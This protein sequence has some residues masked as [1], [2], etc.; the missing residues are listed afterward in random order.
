V[1]EEPFSIETMAVRATF[2]RAATTG[3]TLAAVAAA[4]AGAL[5]LT[6]GTAS[7]QSAELPETL[8]TYRDWIAF[9]YMEDGS[10]VCFA[11]TEPSDSKL[12]RAGASRGDVF[13]LVTNFTGKDRTNEPSVDVGYPLKDGSTVEVEVGGKEFDMMVEGQNAW[14]QDPAREPDLIKAMK[15]GTRMTVRGTS[16]RGTRSTDTFS[17]LGVT[18]AIEKIDSEC[19]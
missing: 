12:S 3:R 11:V 1:Q 7:A 14:L 17:L 9:K 8:G 15:A 18:D 16:A 2:H 5:L 19:Q 10:P 13:F 6:P 4:F